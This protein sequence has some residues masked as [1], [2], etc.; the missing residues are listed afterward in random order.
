MNRDQLDKFERHLAALV[1][2]Y[3]FTS[4]GVTV[5]YRDDSPKCCHRFAGIFIPNPRINERAAYLIHKSLFELAVSTLKTHPDAYTISEE[6]TS[7]VTV[8]DPKG[9]KHGS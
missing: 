7:V 3:G 9:G 8:S 1:L 5:M 4:L 6:T 2:D